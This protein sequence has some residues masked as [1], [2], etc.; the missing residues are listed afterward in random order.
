M[1]QK[2]YYVSHTWGRVTTSEMVNIDTMFPPYFE[3]TKVE[4][5]DDAAVD[6]LITNSL[7]RLGRGAQA[8]VEEHTAWL[9][10]QRVADRTEEGADQVRRDW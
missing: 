4:E 7:K 10:G 8:G 1:Y 6:E 2:L 3:E 5:L 9:P